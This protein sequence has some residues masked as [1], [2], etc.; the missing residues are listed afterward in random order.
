MVTRDIRS[1][2]LLLLSEKS[3]AASLLLACKRALVVTD[4]ASLAAAFLAAM[5]TPSFLLS[6]KS[7][8][9]SLLLACKRARDA[10]TCYQL[11]SVSRD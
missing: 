8:A 5:L 9:A 2:V 6:E 7:H 4:C 10:P 3:H 1:L 11:F